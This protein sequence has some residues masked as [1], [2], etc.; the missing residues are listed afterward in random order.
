[1]PTEVDID[2]AERLVSESME[3]ASCLEGEAAPLN[4]D[5]TVGLHD[6][7]GPSQQRPS[8]PRPRYRPST[9]SP[10]SA[11][12]W[13]VVPA[14]RPPTKLP[15]SSRSPSWT[16]MTGF[17]LSSPACAPLDHSTSDV[18]SGR[19]DAWRARVP[20]SRTDTRRRRRSAC[21][22]SWGRTPHPATRTFRYP[23]Q[24]ARTCSAQS[25]GSRRLPRL[26]TSSI[27]KPIS[28]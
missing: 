8:V 16:W 17:L 3:E 5:A 7:F 26:T 27:L 21:T 2:N 15:T 25:S 13:I 20:S 19:A 1:V 10:S 23:H 14:I 9:Q 6:P 4:G 22:R 18:H 24:G 12:I 11:M 28:L